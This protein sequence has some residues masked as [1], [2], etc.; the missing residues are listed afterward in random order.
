MSRSGEAGRRWWSGLHRR[1]WV[2]A[3]AASLALTLLCF[4]A[5]KP[6]LLQ[7]YSFS[8]KVTGRNG[9]LLRLTLSR[10]EKYRTFVPL[11]EFSAALKE[12]VLLKED[13]YFFRHPGVNPIAVVRAFLSTYFSGGKRVGASTISMQLARLRFGLKTRSVP[14][15][16]WQMLRAVQ[17]E[18]HYSK[19]ELFEAYLNLAPY[20]YNVEGAGAASLIFFHKDAKELTLPESLA[21]AVLPQNP[22]RRK[23]ERGV[24]KSVALQE[25][26]E[27]LFRDWVE[28]HPEDRESEGLIRLPIA[29]YGRADLR[30]SAPHLSETLLRENPGVL[31]L[32]S[33]IDP[34]L[35]EQIEKIMGR[36]VET[37]RSI[38]VNNA[39]AILVDAPTM[40]VLASV[41][42]VNFNDAAIHGQVDGTRMKRSPGSAL[43]P[44][45]YA[46]AFD[47]GVVHPLSMI[48]DTPM[49]FGAY[50]PENFDRK[51]LGPVTA[52]DALRLSRNVPAMR[53]AMQLRSPTFYQ[54]LDRAKIAGLRPERDYGLSLVLGG[55][56]VTMRELATLYAMLANG[57]EKRELVFLRNEA[58]REGG[59]SLLSQEAAFLTLDSLRSTP[60]PEI[61][62]G[63]PEVYWKTG[64]SNGF[65]DAWT[66]GVFG[67]YVL[68]VWIGDF[69]GA[70][71]P[72]YVG[73]QTAAPLFFS[74]VHSIGGPAARQDL[75][76]PMKKTA[77][78]RS[79]D[80]C[81]PTGDLYDE[82]CPVRVKG[83]FIPGVS[84][85]TKQNVFRRVLIDSETGLRACRFEEGK[86]VWKVFEYWPSD[87]HE[88][89]EQ[90]GIHKAALPG[91]S[92]G[93][94]GVDEGDNGHAPRITSP[95]ASVEYQ[96][97]LS[98]GE[99]EQI[100]LLAVADADVKS[101]HWFLGTRYLGE[102][103]ANEPFYWKPVPG[104]H[105]VRAVD[106][107]GR[108][109][110]LRIE[111]GLVP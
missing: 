62:Y 67:R 49:S 3:F 26:R 102:A 45:I 75:V 30:F 16:V 91:T 9:E 58:Q 12:A 59:V 27:N 4:L 28:A 109:D 87:L 69:T 97:R 1:R 19:D 81:A 21:L 55:A 35:Q 70:S 78:V 44:F 42:S 53:L 56:E 20:G 108:A 72:S 94:E 95:Q 32:R 92:A 107:H 57:G 104:K 6:A 46:L 2:L 60:R 13:R 24:T 99:H 103:S 39:S 85:I 71:N 63:G 47:Q 54:F 61:R 25:A 11:S 10:D 79:V 14:G 89:F 8:R 23:L 82:L 41:G 65:H 74:I 98:G 105:V 88:A 86:T 66:A 33:T 73:I 5:W 90:M 51:F 48:A 101:L 83:W 64:T 18:L 38:G 76:E 43:K 7:E 37:M 29:T 17:L 68:V 15:K 22:A 110:S 84:P 77:R 106:D 31:N 111:V 40:E 80:I 93:C 96:V 52:K 50:D 100:P 34:V 36:T